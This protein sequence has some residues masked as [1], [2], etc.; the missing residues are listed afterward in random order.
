M[1]TRRECINGTVRGVL[2]DGIA[3]F[4]GIPYTGEPPVGKNRW[5]PPVPYGIED[6]F[7]DADSFAASP[8]QHSDGR[9]PT[10]EDCLRLNIWV[11]T[12][13]S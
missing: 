6:R 2:D 1:G 13:T 4:K 7:I 8:P 9:F 5:M 10:S 11:N 3:S 12:K